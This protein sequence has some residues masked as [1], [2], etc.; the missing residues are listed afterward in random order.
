MK[1]ESCITADEA[2]AHPLEIVTV[3][4]T[5]ASLPECASQDGNSFE[6]K[7]YRRDSNHEYEVDLLA[8]RRTLAPFSAPGSRSSAGEP[9]QGQHNADHETRTRGHHPGVCEGGHPHAAAD[10]L[11][12]KPAASKTYDRAIPRPGHHGRRRVTNSSRVYGT[13]PTAYERE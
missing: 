2:L 10:R 8:Q 11:P 4:V 6:E 13:P 12:A 1:R 3:L 9:R 5:P 7:H